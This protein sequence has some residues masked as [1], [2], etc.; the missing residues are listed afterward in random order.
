MFVLPPFINLNPRGPCPNCQ[1]HV[2]TSQDVCPHCKRPLSLKEQADIRNYAAAQKDKGRR[3]GMI[4][5]IP[6]IL[7]FLWIAQG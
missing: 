3:L 6:L 7:L 4:L 2:E 5:F 1:L